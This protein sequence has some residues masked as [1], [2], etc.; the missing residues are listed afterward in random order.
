M[1]DSRKNQKGF[2]LIEILIALSLGV[3][4]IATI[5]SVFSFSL[6]MSEE[7]YQANARKQ[8]VDGICEL[9][10]RELEDSTFVEV[11]ETQP[12][13]RENLHVFSL[14]EGALFLDDVSIFD[15]RYATD[16]ELRITIH[17]FGNMFHATITLGDYQRDFFV[18]CYNIKESHT[19]TDG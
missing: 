6:K 10:E 11:S 3:I 2:T 18:Q 14:Q 17:T 7:N 19:L 12:L 1:I 5:F 4:V 9:L 8:T 13:N 15:D 16:A